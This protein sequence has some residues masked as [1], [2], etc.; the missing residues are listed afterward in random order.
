MAQKKTTKKKPA[1]AAKKTAKKPEALDTK[2]QRE[3]AAIILFVFGIIT[4]LLAVIPGE[5]GWF[6]LHNSVLGISG[7]CAYIVPILL[8]YLAVIISMDKFSKSIMAKSF[9][10][11]LLL[12]FLSATIFLFKSYEGTGFASF[13]DAIV[14]EYNAYDNFGGGVIGTVF[15]YPLGALLG[16]T[17]AKIIAI[18]ATLTDLMII[19]GTTVSKLTDSAQKVHRKAKTDLEE[20]KQ[21]KAERRELE[22]LEQKELDELMYDEN[23]I[24]RSKKQPDLNIYDPQPDVL[25]SEANEIEEKPK[26][27]RKKAAVAPQPEPVQEKNVSNEDFDSK[28]QAI[29]DAENKRH[30][31]KE[32]EK[33]ENIY[34]KEQAIEEL[35][36]AQNAAASM[37]TSTYRLPS[38]SLLASV[39]KGKTSNASRE[40]QENADILMDTLEN[41]GVD[42]EIVGI[43]HGPTVTRYDI[44]PAVGVRINKITNLSADIA[45][46]LA[47]SSI[48]IAPIPNKA[49]IGI[50]VPNK[51]KTMVGLRSIL[52]SDGFAKMKS[53]K[54]TVALGENIA[55]EPQFADLAKMPH[56]LIAGTTGSGKS[57]C[58]NSMIMSILYNAAPSEV[59]FVMIDPKG[60]EL[61]VYNGIPHMPTPVVKNPHKAAGALAWAVKEMMN[62]YALLEQYKV[63]D[64]KSYNKLAKDDPEMISMTQYVIII[65]E[66]ADLMMVSP[67]EVEDSICRLAQMARAAGMH[68]V[69]ATQSPRADVITGLI[70]AN[71]PSR[72]ALSVSNGLDSRIILDQNGA[73][74]LLGNG[75]ML[76][77]PIG[78]NKPMRIQGCFVSDEEIEKVTGFIKKQGRGEYNEDIDR[79]FDELATKEKGKKSSDMEPQG[80]G[81]NDPL[82]EKAIEIILEYQ[83]ASTSFIQRKLSVGY[84]RG[85][86]II[87]E[88]EQMGI[89]GPSEGAKPRKILITKEEWLER[90]A[91]KPDDQLSLEEDNTSNI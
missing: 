60:V 71:I 26:R 88:I 45:L 62:R 24:Y 11:S 70:K 15:G 18:I 44:K 34:T 1:S 75:D 66:L 36:Q 30:Q 87:D 82:V 35:E 21:R 10:V 25:E 73:E 61:S 83:A 57:V 47:T 86:R 4:F 27:R 2:K 55:G 9:E 22:A 91:M 39:K 56:L 52:E 78:A 51:S 6:S 81:E 8:I 90:N 3:I 80:E 38:T 23:K 84:A 46:A 42:A 31:D 17:G 72:I 37:N 48:R 43:T 32:L 29:I 14:N 41:F 69:I 89:I 12:M 49:A 20:I 50:E 63:R 58:L 67:G 77:N 40:M 59:Q 76:F 13:A 28:M 54:L 85:A 5:S 64:I 79:Q 53:K 68:L 74:K 33:K 16:P 7:F 65:D 19:T